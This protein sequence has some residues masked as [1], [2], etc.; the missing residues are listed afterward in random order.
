MKLSDFPGT[1]LVCMVNTRLFECVARIFTGAKISPGS[2]KRLT[3]RESG[4]LHLIE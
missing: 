4:T 1:R 3:L 2:W